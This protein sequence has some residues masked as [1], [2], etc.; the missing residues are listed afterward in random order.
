MNKFEKLIE[1]IINDDDQKARAL[2]HDIVV[3]KSRDIYE[4]IMDEENG[5]GGFGDMQDQVNGDEAMAE[6]D[7]EFELDG[8][9]DA[10]GELDGDFP[11]DDDEGDFGAD[12]E[13]GGEEE[14]GDD[15]QIMNIDAKLDELLAKFDEIMGDG[16]E[17][18]AGEFG[19]DDMGGDDMG[20]DMGGDDMGDDMGGEEEVGADDEAGMF[21]AAAGSGKSGNP[22]AKKGSGKSGSA[23]SGKSGSAASGKSGSAKSGKSGKPFEG[24][25]SSSELMREYVDKIQDMNLSGACE[26]D[27]VGGAGKKTSINS[28]SIT[29]PGADFGGKTVKATGGEQN[30]DGKSPTKASNEYNKGQGQL[31]SGNVNVPGGKAGAPKATGHEYTKDANG[32]EGKTTDGTVP[33]AKKS[34]QVQNTGRR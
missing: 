6:D 18:P 34:V 9:D 2:F 7:E 31:K 11:A 25:Q 10:D 27:A 28:K 30:Q 5:Q 3:E 32:A 8:D 21:E 12:D 19:D 14:M 13:M 24:R 23:A 16:G 20:D 17:E 15:D 29:G 1:Y 33:V 4:S 22:F 26:G